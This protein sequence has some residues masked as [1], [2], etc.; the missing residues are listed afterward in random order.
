MKCLCSK[1]GGMP[2]V[3]CRR[4][5]QRSSTWSTRKQ[6]GTA[7]PGQTRARRTGTG[8]PPGPSSSLALASLPTSLL[9]EHRG[10]GGGGGA[11]C[12]SCRHSLCV[13]CRP[14]VKAS[15]AFRTAGVRHMATRTQDG[16]LAAA[17]AA[18]ALS[19]VRHV[20]P[21]LL[22]LFLSSAAA[23]MVLVHYPY[24]PRLWSTGQVR[25]IS[26]RRRLRARVRWLAHRAALP[27]TPQ[28]PSVLPVALVYATLMGDAAGQKA[29]AWAERGLL[30]PLVTGQGGLLTVA[31]LQ[32]VFLGLYVRGRR[33]PV[34]ACT[35]HTV[36]CPWSPCAGCSTTSRRRATL[37]A[38][39]WC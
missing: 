26:V 13:L 15:L 34:P 28:T 3:R 14:S 8:T 17:A 30:P 7:P 25:P 16:A 33:N 11:R 37:A 38:Q 20:W 10:R 5:P 12:C 36:T 6:R 21:T 2:H 24:M 18:P 29:A 32:L 23:M 1:D 19:L 9:G 35:A 4:P 22:A 27:L 31:A 39:T